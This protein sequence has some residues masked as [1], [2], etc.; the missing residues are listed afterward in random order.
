MRSKIAVLLSALV[1]ASLM[2]AACAPAVTP[3]TAPVPTTAPAATTAPVATSAPAATKA[4]EATKPPAPTAVP[5]VAVPVAAKDTLRVNAGAFPDNLDPQQMSFLA[6][7]GH[8]NKVYE[9]LTRLD[10]GLNTVPAAAES[11]KYNAD[12]TELVFTL[13]KGLKYS[14]G[15]ILNAKRFEFSILRNIDPVTAGEYAGITD[16][17]TGAPEW[18]A[19]DLKKATADDL[20]KL[21]AAVKVQALDAAGAACK[22]Y[23]QA[24]CLTLKVGFSHSTPYFH[25]VASLWVTFPAKEE[26]IKAGGDTWSRSAKY[27]LGN[28]PFVWQLSKRSRS[29]SSSPTPITGR[30]LPSTTLNTTTSPIQL[31][32]WLPTRTMSS[33]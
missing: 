31:L 33:T 3:T 28:G 15:S 22:D 19:A 5:T 32:P 9:G 20:A 24:D 7:I 16:D 27:Q 4:P 17:I 30:V 18:R 23:T 10:K 25:T 29:R 21:K 11:W 12:A 8:A 14:D 6:E 26:L 1:L 13:R 2:L